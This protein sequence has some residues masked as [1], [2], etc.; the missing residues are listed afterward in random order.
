MNNE[1]YMVIELKNGKLIEVYRFLDDEDE[2]FVVEDIIYKSL[3]E[4]FVNYL[5]YQP[6]KSVGTFVKS[7]IM[8]NPKNEIQVTMS[9]KRALYNF[10]VYCSHKDTDFNNFLQWAKEC[11][12]KERVEDE[13]T[14]TV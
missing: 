14:S 1:L 9:Q 2:Y 12:M 7:I 3:T 5:D 13:Q 10:H 8:Y 6:P 11:E 4:F